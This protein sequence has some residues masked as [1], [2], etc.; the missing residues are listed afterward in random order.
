MRRTRNMCKACQLTR[1]CKLSTSCAT[2][3]ACVKEEP[4]L[5]HGAHCE[6]LTSA[7]SDRI[8]GTQCTPA[9]V[10]TSLALVDYTAVQLFARIRHLPLRPSQPRRLSHTQSSC[11]SPSHPRRSL[12]ATSLVCQAS[13]SSRR[14]PLRYSHH[15][16]PDAAP[17]NG[18]TRTAQSH[19]LYPGR[20]AH[21][22]V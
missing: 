10:V 18:A 4:L 22:P 2:C 8:P 7:R 12:P 19:R 1:L 11:R 20:R 15:S 9:K 13:V 14:H 5:H 21:Q 6:Q 16:S 17:P 3:D